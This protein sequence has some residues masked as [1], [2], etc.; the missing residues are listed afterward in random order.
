MN[1]NKIVNRNYLDE[2]LYYGGAYQLQLEREEEYNDIV[3]YCRD[4][5]LYIQNLPAIFDKKCV[6]ILIEHNLLLDIF[7]ISL[8]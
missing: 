3:Q 1:F 2:W 4:K 6:R 5:K 8:K 7:F